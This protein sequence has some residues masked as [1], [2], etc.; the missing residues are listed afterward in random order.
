MH[1]KKTVYRQHDNSPRF[2]LGTAA[3]LGSE[4]DLLSCFSIFKTGSSLIVP[5]YRKV[6]QIHAIS[7]SLFL[8]LTI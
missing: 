6:A 2:L 8:T 4:I 7:L 1:I 3:S 5:F